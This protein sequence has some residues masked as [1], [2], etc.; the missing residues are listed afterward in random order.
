MDACFFGHVHAY[1][2]NARVHNGAA[3][4]AGPVYITIGDGGNIEGLASSWLTQPSYSLFRKSAY[5]H[6]ELSIVNTTHALWEWH[7]NPDDEPTVEDSV[8]II[9]GSEAVPTGRAGSKST[10][11]KRA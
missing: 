2:R 8:W 1:E 9:K 11:R 6:G 10:W 7:A 4:P 3:D 5:G